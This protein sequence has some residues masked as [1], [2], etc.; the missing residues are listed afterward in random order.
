M[1]LAMVARMSS[2]VMESPGG[3]GG[4][5]SRVV[6]AAGGDEAGKR[7]DAAEMAPGLGGISRQRD[8]IA[9]LQRHAEFE[10]VDRVQPEA[11]DEQRLRRRDVLR[12]DVLERERGDDQ[13]LDFL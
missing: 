1:I 8:A 2:L 3:R 10:R 9:L 7:G 12:P 13:L 11:F 4:C 5:G 6:L